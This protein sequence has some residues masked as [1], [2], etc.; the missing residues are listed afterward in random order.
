MQKCADVLK[1]VKVSQFKAPKITG[2]SP[3]RG[4]IIKLATLAAGEE[5]TFRGFLA[6]RLV[7]DF[8]TCSSR[9]FWKKNIK[10]RFNKQCTE[11]YVLH[12]FS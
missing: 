4:E 2:F 10:L 7:T 6:L 5:K 8:C 12:I 1:T 11:L 9:I 3:E